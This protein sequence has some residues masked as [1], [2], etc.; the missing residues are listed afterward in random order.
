MKDITKA[1]REE[2]LEEA[3]K[4]A[5]RDVDDQ[6]FVMIRPYHEIAAAIRALKTKATP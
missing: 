3:A 6:G 2:A 4:E 1:I 5:E